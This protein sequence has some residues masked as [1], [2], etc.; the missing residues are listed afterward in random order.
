LAICLMVI[1]LAIGIYRTARADYDVNRIAPSAAHRVRLEIFYKT[2]ADRTWVRAWMPQNEKDLVLGMRWTDTDLIVSSEEYRGGNRLLEWRGET[3]GSGKVETAFTVAIPKVAYS[4][5]PS[6]QVPG[7]PADAKLPFLE[8]SDVIQTNHPAIAELA[9]ELAPAGTSSLDALRRVYDYCLSLPGP[10]ASGSAGYLPAASALETLQ[11]QSGS[12]LGKIRLFTA[13]SRHQGFPTRLVQGIFLDPGLEVAP[14]TWAEVRLSTAWV[15]F[16]L[17]RDL[18]ART[19]GGLV[20]FVRGDRPIVEA[21]PAAELQIRYGVERSFAVRGRLTEGGSGKAST[22]WLGLWAALEEAGIPIDMQRIV[23][24]IP[25]GAFM[26]VLIRNVLGLRTFGF[27]MPLLLAIAATRTGLF[28]T[29]SAFLFVIGLVCVIRL[30][31]KPLRLLHFPLQAIM[32]TA[33]VAAVMGLATAG[34]I[35]GNLKLAHLTFIPVVVLT[36]TTEKFTIIIEEE[37]P[38]E[39]LKVTLMSMLAICFC[40]LVMS[41]WTLQA[42]VLTFPESLLT[43]VFLEIVIGGWTGM[44]LLEHF[45]FGRVVSAPGGAA[46]A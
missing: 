12:D 32:L 27:F 42:L 13:L 25:F 7:P 9:A 6:F 46:G 4:I 15:P 5:N 11:S 18:F 2:V 10:D 26:S 33:V 44:R 8:S 23:L 16:H 35:L 22:S 36:I 20:P 45:R 38:L 17:E 28:W 41:S 1:P 24:M 3:D 31:A 34:A 40:F 29:L 43:V 19:A 39:V 37:G 21:D 14:A 30:L